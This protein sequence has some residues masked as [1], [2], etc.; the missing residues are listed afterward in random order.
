MSFA[1]MWVAPQGIHRYLL[2]K[3]GYKLLYLYVDSGWGSIII[4]PVQM[5]CSRFGGYDLLELL[6]FFIYALRSQG[7]FP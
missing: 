2:K 7:A 5:V 3:K 1:H 6:L 4:R